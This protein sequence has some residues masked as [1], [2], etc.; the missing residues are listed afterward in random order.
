MNM[1]SFVFSRDA[2]STAPLPKPKA[3]GF[4]AI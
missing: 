3:I 1:P 2:S 4:S